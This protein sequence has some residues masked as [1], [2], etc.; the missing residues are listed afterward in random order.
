M[1]LAKVRD[2]WSGTLLRTGRCRRTCT[3]QPWGS[4]FPALALAVPSHLQPHRMLAGFSELGH[5]P[6]ASPPQLLSRVPALPPGA[7]FQHQGG[8]QIIEVDDIGHLQRA[9]GL[10]VKSSASPP[11]ADDVTRAMAGDF[12]SR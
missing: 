10:N 5:V 12:A 1:S 4:A 8:N 9:H 6:A 3:F 2:F 11:H 7:R